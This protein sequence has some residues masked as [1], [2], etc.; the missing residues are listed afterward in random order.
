METTKKTEISDY[1]RRSIPDIA[2]KCGVKYDEVVEV[3][4]ELVI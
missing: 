4:K 1:I 3:M 2:R